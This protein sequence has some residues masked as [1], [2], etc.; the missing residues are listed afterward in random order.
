MINLHRDALAATGLY[1][2]GHGQAGLSVRANDKQVV[3]CAPAL[4]LL[5][6]S[7]LACVLLVPAFRLYR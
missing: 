1:L 5:L 2:T 4:L 7:E 3:Y 6:G